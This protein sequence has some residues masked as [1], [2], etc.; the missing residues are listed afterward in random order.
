MTKKNEEN[1]RVP[2]AGQISK[3]RLRE[4]AVDKSSPSRGMFSLGGLALL[5][6]FNIRTDQAQ[7]IP[8]TGEKKQSERKKTLRTQ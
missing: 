6:V 3:C 5:Q 8:S 4:L 2:N 7:G 1:L